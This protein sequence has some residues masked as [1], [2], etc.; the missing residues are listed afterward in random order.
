MSVSVRSLTPVQALYLRPTFFISF[1]IAVIAICL[2]P[3]YN[4]MIFGGGF[5]LYIV[6]HQLR[7]YIYRLGLSRFYLLM[8]IFYFSLWLSM[9][10]DIDFNTNG[11]SE[12][13]S[14]PSN[15]GIWGFITSDYDRGKILGELSLRSDSLI[16]WK[17]LIFAPLVAVLFYVLNV[18]LDRKKVRNADI[19]YLH[20]TKEVLFSRNEYV[21][22]V[23][24]TCFGVCSFFYGLPCALVAVLFIAIFAW[25]R[26][27]YTAVIA[28]GCFVSFLLLNVFTFNYMAFLK[29]PFVFSFY[30]NTKGFLWTLKTLI[31][32][33]MEHKAQQSAIFIPYLGLITILSITL[34][35]NR[36]I[37][38]QLSTEMAMQE[39][40]NN[41]INALSFAKNLQTGKDEKVT[42]N[43]L[44]VHMFINGTTGS[45][46]TVAFMNFVVDACEKNLPLVYLD[47]KGSR[48]L[49]E[50]IGRI[51][52]HYGRTFRVFSLS[53]NAV[54]N[55]MCY[56]FLGSG[57]FTERK[58]RI[59]NLFIAAEE[60]GTSYYQDRVERLVNSVFRVIDH[61]DLKVDLFRF[62]KLV[63][64]I[65]DLIEMS[66][67]MD[68]SL[69]DYFLWIR[70]E[71]RDNPRHNLLNKLDVFINSVYGRL[72]DVMGKDN[73]INLRKSLENNEIVLF[74]FD[75]S[76]YSLDTQKVAKMV[77]S[78]LN[79]TF[80][81]FGL[82]R[83][84][85]KTYCCFDEF[86]S[87]ETEAIASTIALHRSNGMHAII[88]TQSIGLINKN[89]SRAILAN[90]NT[91]LSLSCASD[92][93]SRIFADTFG[94]YKKFETAT[95]IKTDVQEVTGITSKQVED[96]IVSPQDIKNIIPGSGMGYLYRK[97]AG[98][99][100]VKVQVYKKY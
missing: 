87:Y 1:M 86:K 64:N 9:T 3:S 89:I 28:A 54:S 16:H 8:I 88:G 53:P 41:D 57:N 7:G 58:N 48:D 37:Y 20:I 4:V 15:G 56:D 29:F 10:M 31:V 32:Y 43:E 35:R 45:G 23:G 50:I 97:A 77:I 65:D 59:M 90:C 46:K 52:T 91:Y 74:L 25:L 69:K 76:A 26:L 18:E 100:P 33:A 30:L 70:D 40:I 61:H 99:K 47:G 55:P 96:Y 2:N 60:A 19:E 24:L 5:L 73:V 82:M 11:F 75:A 92:E 27:E 62:L 44:N 83:K 67:V 13:F 21:E 95:H 94:T 72:F 17:M 79:S 78:N 81:E 38:S 49:E 84:F 36:N 71:K 98:R 51:A 22:I 63:N 6:M 14:S 34:L 66:S 42:H 93:D 85:V 80:A 12:Y 39:S 68:D